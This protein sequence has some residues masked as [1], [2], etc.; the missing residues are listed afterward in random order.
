MGSERGCNL[1]CL[2]GTHTPFGRGD[3]TVRDHI[4][5]VVEAGPSIQE[6]ERWLYVF[7]GRS[8]RHGDGIYWFSHQLVRTAHCR[9]CRCHPV[10]FGARLLANCCCLVSKCC[11][12]ILKMVAIGVGAMD[13]GGVLLEALASGHTQGNLCME[14]GD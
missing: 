5:L 10:S 8:S 9:D 13:S 7:Q 12:R 4:C 1:V 2:Y 14:I 6:F 11:H 3:S